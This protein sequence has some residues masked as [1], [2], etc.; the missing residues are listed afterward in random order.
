MGDLVNLGFQLLQDC[1]INSN[2]TVHRSQHTTYLM[3]D[4]LSSKGY[5]GF[6]NPFS[7]LSFFG[8]NIIFD[9]M[10]VHIPNIGSL[11]LL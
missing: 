8:F 4:S 11:A 1:A 3:R 9:H 6:K 10:R 2:K 5:S 7:R